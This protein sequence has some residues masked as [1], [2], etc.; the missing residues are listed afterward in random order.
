MFIFRVKI[1]FSTNYKLTCEV[2]LR[3]VPLFVEFLQEVVDEIGRWARAVRPARSALFHN[4]L[5]VVLH[6]PQRLAEDPTVSEPWQ[7]PYCREDPLDVEADFDRAPNLDVLNQLLDPLVVLLAA[8]AR[9]GPPHRVEQRELKVLAHADL[10]GPASPVA[11]EH[12]EKVLQLVVDERLGRLDFTEPKLAERA[13]C[14]LADH[15][16]WLAR[17]Q[18]QAEILAEGRISESFV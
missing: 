6:P 18:E 13:N 12:G 4:L 8:V 7:V 16:P 2:C 1:R 15:F 3:I 17:T 11:V 10:V 14:V 9:N 5:E